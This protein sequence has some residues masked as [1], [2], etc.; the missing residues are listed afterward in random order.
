MKNTDSLNLYIMFSCPLAS[1][2]GCN[3]FSLNEPRFWQQESHTHLSCQNDLFLPFNGFTRQSWGGRGLRGGRGFADIVEYFRVSKSA[4]ETLTEFYWLKRNFWCSNPTPTPNP[5]A[6]PNHTYWMSHRTIRILLLHF[7][8]AQISFHVHPA[9]VLQAH[10]EFQ[11]SGTFRETHITHMQRWRCV[12][13]GTSDP[14]SRFWRNRRRRGCK[15]NVSENY[16]T[17]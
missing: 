4:S 17:E 8:W 16:R 9:V 5:T 3:W 11:L 7:L 14:S 6:N 12:C 1:C 10:R 13:S 15:G 2:S